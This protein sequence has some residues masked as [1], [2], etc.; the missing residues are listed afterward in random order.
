MI[1]KICLSLVL[2]ILISAGIGFVFQNIIGFWQGATAAIIIHFLIFYLFNPG[3]KSQVLIES[4][5]AAFDELILTQTASVNCPCGQNTINV[6]ILLNI[7]N[8]FTCEKCLSKFRVNVSFDTVLLTEPFNIANAFN[9]L[10][11]KELTYNDIQ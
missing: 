2:T 4:E 8:I 6:P 1:K 11:S 9:V 10:K 3:Q 7:D 5:K